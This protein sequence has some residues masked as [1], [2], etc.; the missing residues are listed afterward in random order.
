MSTIADQTPEAAP[1]PV[2]KKT[3]LEGSLWPLVVRLHFYAG[4]LVA[5]FLMIAALTGLAYAFTPQLD[6]F[7]YADELRVERVTDRAGGVGAPRPLA[8]QVRAARGAHPEGAVAAVIPAPSADETTRVV[9]DVPDLGERQRTVYVDPYTTEVKGALTTDSGSTPV[10]T[11]LSELHRTLHLG[12]AGTLYSEMAASWLWVIAG[13][14]VLMWLGRRRVYRRSSPRRRTFWHDRSSRGLLRTRGRHATLGLWLAAGLLLLSATG[15]T[16]TDRAG[17]NFD[18]LQEKLNSAPPRL[19][20][21]L[22]GEHAGHHAES[23]SG[24]VDPATHIDHVLETTRRAGLSGPVEISP[25]SQPGKAWTV[26]QADHTWPVHRDA[27]A[28][29]PTGH[30]V[31]ARVNWADHPMMAKLSTLGI[32]LHMGRLF[33]IANQLVLAVLAVGLLTLLF[34]GYRMWWQRR[35]T[36][37]ADRRLMGRPSVLMGRPPARGAI[38]RVPAPALVIGTALVVVIGWALPVL[39]LSLL[40]FLALDGLIGLAKARRA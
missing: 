29:E 23:G 10:T 5:P 36:R 4:L 39:G 24:A 3:G 40:A 2:P 38:R 13:A 37:A 30:A 20:T 8:D 19:N 6:R 32:Q 17:A 28:V 31:T 27:I 25:P 33:G 21:A 14:G 12:E 7:I 22:T 35:P 1:T 34:W 11:W 16:W 15:L 26:T 18:K 9:L